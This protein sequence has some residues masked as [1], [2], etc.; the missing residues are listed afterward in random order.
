M[1]NLMAGDI[2]RTKKEY[3]ETSTIQKDN[4]PGIL[5]LNIRYHQ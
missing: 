3:E 4:K 2:S 5:A 1:E